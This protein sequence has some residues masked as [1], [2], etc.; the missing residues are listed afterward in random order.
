MVPKNQ[1]RLL[2]LCAALLCAVLPL[3]A[4]SAS[5]QADS[6][7]RL[8]NAKYLEQV[9]TDG[10]MARRAVE[11][12]FLHN[13][14]YL[15]CDSALWHVDEKL[16][17]CYGHV[18]LMQG[19]SVLTSEQLDYVIDDNLAQF[20]GGVV[21][22]RNKRDNLL[23]TRILDYNTK[24][25]LAVFR[26]GASMLSEEGQI[27][28]SDEGMYFNSIGLFTFTG[29]VNMFADSVFVKTASLNY[30]SE[31]ARADFVTDVDFW[32]D[33]NM[34]SAGGGWY[35]RNAET[36]FF[37][38]DVHGLG[39][40]QESWS[41]SLYYYRSTNDVLMLGNVQV[42]D[43]DNRV[44]AMGDR[45]H[46]IDSLSR[47]TLEQ[48]ASAALWDDA[49]ENADTTYLGAT[50]FVYETVKKC[51]IPESEVKTAEGRL[52]EMLGDPV[53]EYRR[54]AAQEAADAASEAKKN[55]PLAQAQA[56]AAAA[57]GR[58]GGTPAGVKAPA[59]G[60]RGAIQPEIPKPEEGKAEKPEPPVAAS[61]SLSFAKDSL[62]VATDSLSVGPDS[63][64]VAADTLVAPP[65]DTTKIGFL[66]ATGDIRIFRKDMQVRCDSLR[67]NDLDS[68][69][70]LYKEPV[71]WNEEKRQYNSDSLFVLIRDNKMDRANLLGNAFIHTEE[72]GG[73]FDQ[74]KSTDIIAY[75][76]DSTSLRR[77]DALGGVN[78]LFYL[79]ENETIATVNKV[80]AQMLSATLENGEVQRV[81][82]FDKPKS[83]A[84]P[85]VQLPEAEH[86]IK[87][88]NWMPERRPQD[89]F[90]VTA[91]VVRDSE[92][93]SYE[94]RPHADFK[95]TDIYFPG[96]MKD[97]YKAL[98][99]ARARRNARS[100]APAD[101][102][103]APADSLAARDTTSFA[104]LTG[105]SGDSGSPAGMTGEEAGK[106]DGAEGTALQ[107]TGVDSS[108]SSGSTGGAPADT[109]Y[110]SPRELKRALRI[111]RRDARWAE[112]DARDAAKAAEKQARKEARAK[113]RA[114]KE[115]ARQA[116]QDAID[117]AKLQKYIERYQKQKERNE[118]RKQKPEPAGERPSGVETGGEL[119]APAES[120]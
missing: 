62:A 111:A 106:T 70:R 22:L 26:G 46:Y 82:Y 60:G 34:L 17:N 81:H 107:G 28:E 101:T 89:K 118:G 43:S 56:Q 112:L 102:L 92:R 13:G 7:V 61:D 47:V 6:L 90:D 98:A 9:E 50:R 3:S 109:T 1:K 29:N 85:V 19:E 108:S 30:D 16:I 79:E 15:S 78:A 116:R 57:R 5:G 114:G 52:E 91:M 88:F 14:T 51:D 55:D 40:S 95:Q 84:Y 35:K 99:D 49:G 67:Y 4:Q 36:F 33:D 20:R 58:A 42:Q 110:M 71:V 12:T 113:R 24:D 45:L 76:T 73:Y 77:F 83:D 64:S 41:D 103:A 25:S 115:A 2:I 31:A 18:Q 53:S 65:P 32:K 117:Q 59:E 87:G 74:I 93:E 97:V 96:H 86:H 105:K 100:A 72:P 80:E 66:L 11:P 68:I 120:E 23:R 10:R 94:A 21:Q 44:A 63:L 69:A 38:D 48:R 75:F 54:R 104:G 27:I 8:L 39:V 119:S 37:R